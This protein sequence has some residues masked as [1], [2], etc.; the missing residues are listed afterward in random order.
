M[1]DILKLKYRLIIVLETGERL[2]IT[3]VC[4]EIIWSENENE[5][6]V[7]ISFSAYNAVMKNGQYI[8]ER[9]RPNNIVIVLSNYTGDWIETARGI[10][11]V[12]EPQES[13]EENIFDGEANDILYDMQKSQEHRYIVEGTGTRAAIESI[14][15]DWGVTIGNYDGP[16][17][18]HSKKV[19]KCDY[20]GDIVVDLLDD[21]KKKGAKKCFARVRE[22]IVDII[23]RGTNNVIYSLRADTNVTAV[24]GKISTQNI[25][26]RVVV[27]SKADDERQSIEAVVDGR[28]EYGIRQKIITRD[29]EE[30]L[31]D[32]R[33]IAQDILYDEGKP[34][35]KY[36]ITNAP[37]IPPLRKGD[38]IKIHA[39]TLDGFFFVKSVSHY[40]GKRTM[41][42]E[43]EE[44]DETGDV[45]QEN[46]QFAVG[47]KVRLNGAAYRDSYGT[48]SKKVFLDYV[49]KI[50][51]AVSPER[52]CPYHVG[53]IGWVYTDSIEK[54]Q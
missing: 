36:Q 23:S 49:D 22:G 24:S 48:G 16:N 13:N 26:T 45:S 53:A 15:N 3:N 25:V 2:D 29:S 40:A 50:T 20:V 28:T 33:Q 17:E 47:D 32:A 41:T 42:I 30:S 38:K 11:N 18:K 43:V 39:G 52:D 9:I 34:S 46:K 31:Q 8:S 51:M 5:L 1:I 35:T 10:L 14:F 54:I 6:S 4:E 37:D 44:D 21:A 12:W 19:Y 27:L 7:S